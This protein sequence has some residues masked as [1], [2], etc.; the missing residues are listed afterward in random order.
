MSLMLSYLLLFCLPIYITKK[1]SNNKD[2]VHPEVFGRKARGYYVSRTIL[3]FFG[4]LILDILTVFGVFNPILQWWSAINPLV[5]LPFSHT[6]LYYYFNCLFLGIVNLYIPIHMVPLPGIFL[7][8]ILWAATYSSIF[9]NGLGWG[10][11]MYG[12]RPHEEGASVVMR[13]VEKPP[14]YKEKEAEWE[15][16]VGKRAANKEEA[17]RIIEEGLKLAEKLGMR[18]K[19]VGFKRD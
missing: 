14:N 10:G 17:D 9:R 15:A 11:S 2:L 6:G 13:G 19:I 1:Y 3:S 4:I 8:L 5:S 18:D 16:N 7:C 12:L